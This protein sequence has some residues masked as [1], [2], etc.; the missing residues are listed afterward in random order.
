MDPLTIAGIGA[1]AAGI[2][3]AF[4]N[5]SSQ[6]AALKWQK[7]AQEITW[8]REDNAVQRRAADLKAAGMNPILAA[9]GSASTSAPI[10][11]SAPRMEGLDSSI[12]RVIEAA[13]ASADISQ[14]KA[15]T[16]IARMQPET[17]RID[18]ANKLAQTR[19]LEA[20][21]AAT[22]ENTR[23]ERREND[24]IEGIPVSGTRLVR[25]DSPLVRAAGRASVYFSEKS[26]EL[27][28]KF[29]HYKPKRR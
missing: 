12:M 15:Q 17:I 21:T 8:Q 26:E 18:N 7:K 25:S 14:T 1:A 10:H 22:R 11:V 4:G 28:R 29:N 20:N 3:S 13:R 19:N 23:R 2:G 5:L 9:G 24:V 16:D 27:N 6:A